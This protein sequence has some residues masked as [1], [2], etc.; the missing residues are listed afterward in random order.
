MPTQQSS[1]DFTFTVPLDVF[2]KGGEKWIRGFVTTE[3]AD[4]EGETI[5]Q[6]GLDFSEFM[7]WGYFN[8]NHSKKTEDVLGY[9]IVLEKR[10]TPDGKL[11]HYVEG[12]LISGYESAEKIHRLAKQLKEDGGTRQLG[13]SLQGK[14]DQRAGA[15]GKVITKAR[16]RHVAITSEPV[17]PFT[18][19]DTLVKAL[20]AGA[21]I[22]APAT[23]PGEGFALRQ[24]SL[25]GMRKQRLSQDEA[26]VDLMAKG[27]SR[28]AAERIYRLAAS[29]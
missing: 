8:D 29:I 26:I 22:T 23:S 15:D 7:K 1:T 3:H 20:T 12:K 21:A 18:G 16:V 6:D 24:E 17:N 28:S 9:P 10:T 19:L 4:R 13:F 14:I 5:L 25:G 11:G 27:H 2:E